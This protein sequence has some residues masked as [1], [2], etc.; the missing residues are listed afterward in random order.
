[1]ALKKIISLFLV[2]VLLFAGL[3]APLLPFGGT[4]PVFAEVSPVD[5]VYGDFFDTSN[6]QLN[7][8]SLIDVNGAIRF[9]SDGGSGES[10]F[11]KERVALDE[12]RSF[13]AAFTFRNVSPATPVN[14][15]EGGFTFTL[16]S[17]GNTMVTNTF[18]HETLVA[19]GTTLAPSLSVAFV[20]KYVESS[21]TAKLYKLKNFAIASVADIPIIDLPTNGLSHTKLPG[22]DLTI[23]ELPPVSEYS[24][25]D[26]KSVV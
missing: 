25:L 5:I 22:M 24:T 21:P 6:L 17:A 26:R 12:T 7:G 11:T 2:F 3:P 10:V 18:H 23:S 13:S 8:S 4:L 14:L 1:M 19:E 9:D 20:T 15:S 16:Q